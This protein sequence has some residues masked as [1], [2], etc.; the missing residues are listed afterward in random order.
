M[1]PPNLHGDFPA[2][3]SQAYPLRHASVSAQGPKL[4]PQRLTQRRRHR[5]GDR[6]GQEGFSRPGSHQV[7]VTEGPENHQV[8]PQLSHS[9][10]GP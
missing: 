1:G 6:D 9:L 3:L 8:Q 4:L 7:V 5:Q 2:G 10:A